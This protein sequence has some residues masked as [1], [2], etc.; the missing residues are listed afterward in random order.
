MS[1]LSFEDRVLRRAGIS[2]EPGRR[3][4]A[5][6]DAAAAQTAEA[7]TGGSEA[8]D[9]LSL[10]ILRRANLGGAVAPAPTAPARVEA[11]P[12]AVEP[13][14]T[15]VPA[16]ATPPA[17]TQTQARRQPAP[18]PQR[19]AASSSAPARSQPAQSSVSEP[20]V[21]MPDGVSPEFGGSGIGSTFEPSQPQGQ[22]Q[23]RPEAKTNNPA[24]GAA[25][26]TAELG[27]STAE[28]YA[29]VARPGGV[30]DRTINQST[31]FL[32]M[33]NIMRR[34]IQG[35]DGLEQENKAL[36]AMQGWANRTRD[37]AKD[38]GYAPSTQLGDIATN[39]LNVVPF[40]AERVVTSLPDMAAAVAVPKVYV[41]ART[42]EILNERLK[43]DN[44][45]IEQATVGDVAAAATGA[46]I[47][48]TLERFAT[49]GLFKSGV[50]GS[51]AGARISTQA[52]IQSGTEAL[53]EGA[54]NIAGSAGTVRGVDA[55]ELGTAML[56]GAIVGGGLGGTVQGA[57]EVYD[58]TTPAGRLA[59]AIN[60]DVESAKP[61]AA[62]ADR[63]AISALD[64]N[65]GTA[66]AVENLI[67]PN[68]L[69]NDLPNPYDLGRVEPSFD[70]LAPAQT[71]ADSFSG[72]GL[73]NDLPNPDDRYN[74]GQIEPSFDLGRIPTA[75]SGD[76]RVEPRLEADNQGAPVATANQQLSTAVPGQESNL[77]QGVAQ[78]E[79]QPMSLRSDASTAGTVDQTEL[80]RMLDEVDAR[81]QQQSGTAVSQQ[82]SQPETL[83]NAL[84]SIGR[85]LG[86]NPGEQLNVTEV[87]SDK[88]LNTFAKALSQAFGVNVHWVDFG[89]QGM[90]ATNQAGET[91]NLG[92]FNGYRV[93]DT[94]LVGANAD[95]MDTTW[96]E[97][98]HVLET[99]YADVYKALRDA[100]VKAVDPQMQQRLFDSLN[101]SRMREVGRPM[102]QQELESELV[103]Y[104]VGQQATDPQLLNRLFDSFQDKTL[105]QQFKD[106]LVDILNKLSGALR[107]PQYIKD[108]Q[109][110]IQ[111]RDAIVSAFKEYQKR[112]AAKASMPPALAAVVA[113]SGAAP[114]TSAAQPA[115]PTQ[116]A[117]ATLGRF[118]MYSGY[119]MSA[120][121]VTFGGA[122]PVTNTAPQAK[123]KEPPP[124]PR[125]QLVTALVEGRAIPATILLAEADIFQVYQNT[126]A[127]LARAPTIKARYDTRMLRVA[128]REGMTLQAGPIKKFP[129]TFS[130]IWFDYGGD[131]TKIGDVVRST[132]VVEDLNELN[133]MIEAVTSFF[134]GVSVKRNGWDPAAPVHPSGYRDVFF[135]GAQIAGFPVEL[136]M[137]FAQMLKAKSVAHKLYEQAEELRRAMISREKPMSPGDLSAAQ[138]Q[139]NELERS[140]FEI[141]SEAAE[142]VFDR[143]NAAR[144]SA[145]DMGTPSDVQVDSP[146]ERGAVSPVRGLSSQAESPP[147]G[148][149][150]T[151]TPLTSKNVVPGGNE[152]GIDAT[153]S[154]PIAIPDDSIPQQTESGG[155][156]QFARS[157][158]TLMQ[159]SDADARRSLGLDAKKNKTRDVG[160]ALNA[161]TQ[162]EDGII[163]DKNNSEEAM[164]EIADILVGEVAYQLGTSA[165]TGTGLGW[166]SANYP[167]AVKR[168][169]RVYPEFADDA[170]ARNVFTAIV[171]ITSNGERVATNISNAIKIYDKFRDGGALEPVGT[172]RG[173]MTQAL[174]RLQ[175]L[176]DMYGMDGFHEHLL[177]ELTV[178][179]INASLRKAGKKAN[180]S[181]TADTIMPR[182]ALYFGPKLGAFY[183]NLMGSEGYLTM[184]LWWSRTFN[185]IRGTLI[186]TP[187]K[188]S[189][190]NV[191]Q[192]LNLPEN[193]DEELVTMLAIP[194][195]ESYA[196][197]G[198]KNGTELEKK[199]NTLVKTAFLELNEAPFRAS[200]RSFMISTTRMAQR[201]LEKNGVKLTLADIQ[202]ALWYYEKRLYA[203]LTGRKTDDI[204]YEEAILSY[205]EGDRPERSPA[206]FNRGGSGGDVG[207]GGGA[208]VDANVPA[209]EA[210]APEAAADAPVDSD[211]PLSAAG[212]FSR[213][214]VELAA[215]G[216]PRAPQVFGISKTPAVLKAVGS[217]DQL[218]VM[219]PATVMKVVN[220]GMF[221]KNTEDAVRR[222]AVGMV[223]PVKAR[224]ALTVDELRDVPR[225]IA[226]PVAV[227]RSEGDRAGRRYGYKV[228]LDLVKD[229]NPVVAIVHPD[230]RYGG[231]RA[232]QIASVYPMNED[233][234]L[235]ET[236]SE[237]TKQGQLLF[238]N[239]GKAAALASK[240]DGKLPALTRTT[241]VGSKAPG[242]VP[243]RQFQPLSNSNF[244]RQ[245]ALQG[246]RFAIG[247]RTMTERVSN[248]LANE[249]SRVTDVQ[250]QVV[251][252]GGVMT[253]ETNIEN[254][255][256]RMH[257]RAGNRIDDFRKNTLKPLIEQA[258]QQGV[259]LNDVALYMYANHAAERNAHIAS[260]NPQFAGDGSGM[261]N[262]DAQAVIASLQAKGAQFAKIKTIADNFQAITR[263]TGQALLDGGLIDNATLQSWRSGWQYYVPLKGFER[264]AEGKAT[265]NP[266][267]DP[268]DP[269]FRRAMGRQSRAGQII[270][271]ILKDYE[272]A[273][274]AA[275]KNKLRQAA[276]KFFLQNPDSAL[277]DVDPMVMQ[278]R[279]NKTNNIVDYAIV[280]DE[281]SNTIGVRVNGV[282]RSI[283]INDPALLSDLQMTPLLSGKLAEIYLGVFGGI[284]RTLGKLWTALSPA[285]VLINA[286]RDL[287]YATAKT[288]VERGTGA[289]V[290]IWRDFMPVAYTV[291]RAERNNNWAGNAELRAYY[292][293]YRADGGKTGFMD[294]VGLEQRQQRVISDYRNA[295]ASLK[296]PR[297]YHRLSLR[298]INSAEDLIMDVNAGIENAARVAAYKS[299][300]ERAGYNH[301]NAPKAVREEAATVA[302]NLTVNFN[303]RGKMTPFLAP[304]YLFINPAIQG[305]ASVTK[306]VM[307]KKGGALAGS[308]VG[309]GYIVATMAAGAVGE[310][311][312]PYWDKE[313]NRS[314]KLKNLMW[315]GPNGEQYTVPLAYGLGFFVNLGYAMKDLERG[316]DPWKVAAFM[317]DSFFTHFSPLGAADNAATFVSPTIVDPF[318]VLTS[319]KRE[320]GMPLLP[321]D[322]K[323]GAT[324]DSE[325]YW[326]NT[327][328]TFL[329]R[330]TTWMNEATGGSPGKSGKVDVSPE[331][332]S[333]LLTFTTGGAGTFVKDT[334]KSIDLALN[335]GPDAAMDKNAYPILKAFYRRDTGRGD[336]ASFFENSQ[337][338]KEAKAELENAESD[339]PS[340]NARARIRANELFA[341]LDSSQRYI[342]KQLSLLRK[343]EVEIRDNKSLSR[344]EQYDRLE[345]LDKERRK[346]ESEFNRE[347]YAIQRQAGEPR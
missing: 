264:I 199:A 91:R 162:A 13:Q 54:A 22:A 106:I 155:G 229:G 164:K 47:E 219:D 104:T 214:D 23:P 126:K 94:I 185:R 298:Y 7:I 312:D 310:D 178:G 286:G 129:R 14:Q 153:L 263:L 244:A 207:Q 268:R 40:V 46:V 128:D 132:L 71:A 115:Q 216:D 257:G 151:G 130:K 196:E 72:Q 131:H 181:Y 138:D 57:R 144:Q 295:Q 160:A 102:T 70:P 218:L 127:L 297:T 337:R 123:R 3:A 58:R 212:Q 56:E 9:D 17:A 50:P 136:Q 51:T 210:A 68:R 175:T 83:T 69:V 266:R 256:H 120:P 183:A 148:A 25:A 166:Y 204:G 347:F 171:A 215:N 294:L 283:R 325:R 39:P 190:D 342:V 150:V 226:D 42:N 31:P 105:A 101:A 277:W 292:D 270:E 192:L 24:L 93:G 221:G 317:R 90:T 220:P 28:A 330:F 103:A 64:P 6:Q 67:E 143:V 113:R 59:S 182:A 20:Q 205:A 110:V 19:V 200:D 48:T 335:V 301:T 109:R 202:A 320:N 290:D 65:R 43:N 18:Q 282:P 85:D 217:P 281:G 29:R 314:A 255:L 165:N 193:T 163:G 241:A 73:V 291:M 26:R 239:K 99:R 336:Q 345:F 172:R 323:G 170:G 272:E 247:E 194:Y 340:D 88:R 74:R 55:R 331:T 253:E 332:L 228:L 307:S 306:L 343:E 203:K 246:N 114:V 274:V 211:V 285:F 119:Q 141:Y 271:N 338:V 76:E 53:E 224:I 107:G 77:S 80:Q 186:P 231:D 1:E 98:T 269:F 259:D 227:F 140:Q 81:N 146:N 34:V 167:N 341:E 11:I 321:P 168:L 137:N 250:Q 225:Q 97:L 37:W 248:M 344:R 302:K 316:R 147:L 245:I 5:M 173:S 92:A 38:I 260:I 240:I 33:L 252:Q 324:P 4:A 318:I 237:L 157:T 112:E 280:K 236:N 230:V 149:R 339:S 232:T 177:E 158:V 169:A 326:T 16:V 60:A 89:E 2:G 32:G 154:S 142:E 209:Q 296:D 124:P 179:E 10:R 238:F 273:I 284:N 327:R 305:A 159:Q 278:K 95:L 288:A 299:V 44:K 309:L 133:N 12:T 111:A 121:T 275:E 118:P 15:A 233:R 242:Q 174:D 45:T 311:D 27:A 303:R 258:A 152:A 61:L 262:A 334:I 279:W 267:F 322:Y 135:K 35:K 84:A 308:L 116:T 8:T 195:Q 206:R 289:T 87:T 75:Q 315:F 265:G 191:R 300:I 49:K 333:Y 63:R 223:V 313:S 234:S 62:E 79:A 304:L 189:V 346:L 161:R 208:A 100:V 134:P 293:M 243:N 21:G 156:G 117:P 222:N 329:Q 96:H 78:P 251:A 235:N 213:R 52:G 108:R 197:K 180:S 187:T 328:D 86:V 66:T 319:E 125:E 176:V 184:D 198:Y 261:S 249:V 82:Q 276:L 188:S 36:D 41:A 139:I 254:A 287:E 30:L 201:Q 122:K 145:S